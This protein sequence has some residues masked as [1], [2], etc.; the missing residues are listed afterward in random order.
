MNR[1]AKQWQKWV[2]LY[3]QMGNAGLAC[4]RC[5]ISRPRMRKWWRRYQ[6][7]G[8]KGL[9]GRNRRPK[10]IPFRKATPEIERWVL[11]LR[12]KQTIGARRIQRKLQR[13]HDVHLSPATSSPPAS[14]AIREKSARR[15]DSDST[16]LEY[17]LEEMPFPLQRIKTDRGVEFA[18]Y[19]FPSP[20]GTA[21][22]AA[23]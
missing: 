10:E 9:K 2:Q 8:I 14:Q 12:Q 3:E 18:A 17:I 22:Q 13:L 6:A 23:T 15:S 1:E 5:G 19:D 4:L 20:G 21:R 7:E 11:D 16:N